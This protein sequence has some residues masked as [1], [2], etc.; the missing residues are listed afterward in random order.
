MPRGGAQTPSPAAGRLCG[1][2][3]AFRDDLRVRVSA[4]RELRERIDSLAALAA[5]VISNDDGALS[6]IAYDE[7]ASRAAVQAAFERDR[8]GRYTADDLENAHIYDGFFHVR[9]A[10]DLTAPQFLNQA[11]HVIAA[12][13][14]DLGD[15]LLDRDEVGAL[16][17]A[18]V[19]ALECAG[20]TAIPPNGT[21]LPQAAA[22]EDE[23]DGARVWYRWV[24]GHHTFA[25]CAIFARDA[26]LRAQ[27]AITAADNDALAAALNDAGI[28]VRAT[29]AAMWYTADFPIKFYL[30]KMRPAMEASGARGGFSGTQNSDYE[31]YKAARERTVEAL[32]EK[33]GD[34]A[35]QWPPPVL[36]ALT[37]FH[38]IEVQAAEHHVLVAASKV[39]LDQSLA[40]KSTQPGGRESAVDILREVVDGAISDIAD[41]FTAESAREVRA[42]AAADVPAERPLAVTVE[43]QPM[44]ICRAY[45][46]FWACAGVCTH[47]QADL[48]DGHMAGDTLVCPLHGGKF[49]PRTGGAVHR[50]ANEPLATYPVTLRDGEVFVRL[51]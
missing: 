37:R 39:E 51:T 15:A 47:A 33:F 31:R 2:L 7:T 26:L 28:F 48:A 22:P 19:R 4:A 3:R 21:P 36:A 49:D 10:P 40:Q 8:A 14:A 29:A 23:P 45:G 44:I 13:L 20:V 38:E 1:A 11:L 35:S 41:R 42:C 18:M 9:R 32:F 17:D 24:A 46:S 16:F 25:L 43:G 27:T 12:L 5:Q 6:E 34:R 30:E 50:P